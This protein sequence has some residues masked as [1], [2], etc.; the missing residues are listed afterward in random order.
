MRVEPRGLEERRLLDVAQ[1][2]VLLRRRQRRE[3][4]AAGAF[5]RGAAIQVGD[6]AV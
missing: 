2:L 3:A 4:G 5:A 6:A 1:H